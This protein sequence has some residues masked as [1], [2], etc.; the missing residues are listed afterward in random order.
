MKDA[1]VGNFVHT[2]QNVPEMRE[3]TAWALQGACQRKGKIHHKTRE[4]G[5]RNHSMS[6]C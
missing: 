3:L 6:A 5:G 4:G 1:A 2:S